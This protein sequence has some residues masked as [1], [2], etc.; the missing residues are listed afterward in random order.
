[1]ISNQELVEDIVGH[2]GEKVF[3]FEEP[4]GMLSFST[5]AENL[6]ELIVYLKNHTTFRFTFLT[7][8]TGV[9]YPDNLD[10]ELCVVYHMH[11]WERSTRLRVKVYLPVSKPEVPT[12]VSVFDGANWMERET[13]DFYGVIFIGH[14]NLT[15]IL[16]MEDMDYF[17]M[18][19]EYP[20]EDSSRND[21]ID[22]LFGR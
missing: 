6:V 21:K 4:Y 10:K 11:S 3:A 9:H 12:L 5:S 16:N 7:D 17:P 8:I 15:R 14:P 2:F 18:R 19:K 13:F 20:L 1:M 22:E